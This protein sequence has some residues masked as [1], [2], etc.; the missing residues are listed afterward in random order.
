MNM[1]A[2]ETVTTTIKSL[3]TEILTHVFSFLDHPAPS[4]SRLHDQ[5][6]DGM[7]RRPDN[8]TLKSLGFVNKEWRATVLPLL[9]KNL[10]W[11]FDRCDLLHIGTQQ[12]D[13][14]AAASAA[15]VIPV[16][17]FIR[18][19]RLSSYVK[20]LTLIHVR[21]SSPGTSPI[22]L[23]RLGDGS[24]QYGYS[25]HPV[26]IPHAREGRDSMSTYL[27]NKDNSWL[28]RGIFENID[29][30]RF[31][32]IASPRMLASLLSRAL[33]FGDAW[34]FNMSHHVLSLERDNRPTVKPALIGENETSSS[35]STNGAEAS[36]SASASE[37]PIS[38]GAK[39][40]VPCELFTL[41]P[42]TR[43]L[44]NEG[45]STSVYKSYEFF[46]RRPPSMLGALVGAQDFPNNEP[47]VPST[48]RDFSYV[49]IFP[50]SSHFETLVQHLP[51]VDRFFVQ[52]VP[53]NNILKDRREMEKIDPNDLWL[54]RNTAYS[55][56]MPKLF[57]GSTSS[58]NWRYLHEFESGDAADRESWEMAVQYVEESGAGW[59]VERD[60]VFVR[61]QPGEHDSDDEDPRHISNQ[62]SLHA[63]NDAE[64][65]EADSDD[66]G[67]TGA[68]L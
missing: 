52:L 2:S 50:L 53:R 6:S 54:E 43:I 42:W 59:R 28:W 27:Y 34:L 17:A 55:K 61:K 36:S 66:G 32:I 40:V 38:P 25:P 31:T 18:D 48:V 14:G 51:R 41:R 23:Y 64:D 29:P 68:F 22:G 16:L 9:F 20:S 57:D 10:V 21:D 63:H 8:R 24:G 11:S 65:Y 35:S 45:S 47:L 30:S 37:T 58:G 49:A 4:E 62:L 33:Y 13:A 67:P 7:L 12:D 44:L 5:P 39:R 46:H 15:S 3:P 56:V 1:A 60:G 26:G 19:N